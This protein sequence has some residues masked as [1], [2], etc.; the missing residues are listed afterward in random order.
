MRIAVRAVA[1]IAVV[2]T[3]SGLAIGAINPP[4]CPTSGDPG[5]RISK[6]STNLCFQNLNK[7]Y[8][9]LYVPSPDSSVVLI[10]DGY[11]GRFVKNGKTLG[12][13]FKV[14]EDEDIIWSPDSTAIMVTVNLERDL[15][16]TTLAYTDPNRPQPP[17]ITALVQKDSALR[18]PCVT[19]SESVAVFG[20]S[21]QKGSRQAVLVA[22]LPE[23]CSGDSDGFDA[24]IIAIPEGAILG[25]YPQSVAQKK[26][27]KVML[28]P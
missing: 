1:V 26:F 11:E 25:R 7:K 12:Q 4:E 16:S 13:P 5:F 6:V 10:V 22:A 21:W 28:P 27:H 15:F 8:R 20:L 3:A 9:H 18:H 19:A 23:S 2:F 14:A 24:Y 17:N